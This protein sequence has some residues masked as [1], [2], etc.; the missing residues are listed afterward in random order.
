[1]KISRLISTFLVALSCLTIA[2]AQSQ[3]TPLPKPKQPE[4]PQNPTQ[5]KTKPAGET[6]DQQV[7]EFRDR[8][9]VTYNVRLP[10]AVTDKS[11]RFVTDL[12]QADFEIYE[13]KVKQEDIVSFLAEANLPLD[14][15]LLMDTSNSVKPKL[16]FQRDA[17]VSFLQT[18]LRPRQDRALFLSFNSDIELQQDYTNRIDLLS[19]SID[20]VKA[21]GETRLYDAVYRICEEKM[22]AEAGRRRAI[23]LITDGEDTASE[24]TL[25]DAINIALRS[26]TVV[27]VIS[28]KAAG[29]FGVQAGQVDSAEDKNLKKL[30]ED[31]G[32]RAFFTGTTLQL[33]KGFASVTQELRSQY[34]IA[35]SPSNINFDGRFRQIEVRV[36]GKKDMKIRT[37]KG[38]EARDSSGP[39][40]VAKPN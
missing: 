21:Y 14:I 35:Y 7:P 22:F 24:H 4:T 6:P 40:A 19:Q 36:P 28:N 2:Q 10:L 18:V 20:K 8:P 30:A 26:E 1:M 23:V 12:K 16:K 3:Q 39:A 11:N 34:I 17:A 9:I 5:S 27:F 25:T 37:R 32:G 31:T 38:Y 29:F 13:D 15:A 33:E